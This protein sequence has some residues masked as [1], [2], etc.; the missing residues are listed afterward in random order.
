MDQALC[1]VVR[2]Q[3]E[4]NRLDLVWKELPIQWNKLG[5]GT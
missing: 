5:L 4:E 1:N 3:G 2:M